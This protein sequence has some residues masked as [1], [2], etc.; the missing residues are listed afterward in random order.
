[1]RAC[2]CFFLSLSLSCV[3]DV[4]LEERHNHYGSPLSPSLYAMMDDHIALCVRRAG[5]HTP[6]FF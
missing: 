2:C 4:L 5:E 3:V 6:F 1:M